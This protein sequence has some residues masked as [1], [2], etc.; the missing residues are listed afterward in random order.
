MPSG[1]REASERR[2]LRHCHSALHLKSLAAE[3]RHQAVPD[4]VERPRSDGRRRVGFQD[5]QL[6]GRA[7]ADVH[8]GGPD[9]R[10]TEPQGHLPDIACGMQES[11]S[12]RSD[13]AHAA[14]PVWR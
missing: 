10:V 2:P 7:R 6:F 11:P 9:V 4:T 13:E 3:Q 1:A 8:F 5:S 14:L 12:P